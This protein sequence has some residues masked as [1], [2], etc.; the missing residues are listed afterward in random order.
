MNKKI[1]GCG[2]LL[3]IFL[4]IFLSCGKKESAVPEV[5][6][7]F[8]DVGDFMDVLSNNPHGVF[9]NRDGSSL[10]TQIL[11][12]QFIDG[13][14]VYFGTNREKPLY[15]QL[16]ANPQASY[17]AFPADWEPVVSLNG[18]VV[19]VEDRKTKAR[20]LEG[21]YLNKYYQS[22]DDPNL[23]VF[24]IDVDLIETYSS[25]GAQIFRAK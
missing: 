5:N 4:L 20:A 9:A 16:R 3:A 11:T 15:R 8:R 10:R 23:M 2:I 21:E 12:F 24:Y 25:E 18:T 19:F 14:K 7:E 6:F 13:N 1:I 17:C 22:P